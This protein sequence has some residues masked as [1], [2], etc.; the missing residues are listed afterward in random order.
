MQVYQRY[1]L[2]AHLLFSFLLFGL[3]GC[4]NAGDKVVANYEGSK[5]LL[6]EL[7]R[8]IPNGISSADSTRY[9]REYIRQWYLDQA[10]E[11]EAADQ[12]SGIEQEIA[13]MLADCRNKLYIEALRQ[14]WLKSMN[15]QVSVQDIERYYKDNITQFI[16][17]GTSYLYVY[18]QSKQTIGPEAQNMIKNALTLGA[19]KDIEQL[20]GWCEKNAA[21]FKLDSTL[22]PEADLRKLETTA[23]TNL[24]GIAANSGLRQW[25]S[26]ENGQAQQHFFVMKDVIR[27]GKYI[28][29]YAVRTNLREFVLANRS[30]TLIRENENRLFQRERV[31]N[32]FGDLP[33]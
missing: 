33:K 24:T 16:A 12:I 3:A 14:H 15:N 28:P 10:L 26:Y 2:P 7:R 30:N 1:F 25:T 4:G 13:P 5:L 11:H 31:A 22:V 9:S 17:E 6:T 19:A 21:A 32:R 18:V 23:R 27:Q 20:E 29:L 8:H